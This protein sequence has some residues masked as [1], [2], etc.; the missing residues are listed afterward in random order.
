MKWWF[1]FEDLGENKLYREHNRCDDMFKTPVIITLHHLTPKA[2][3]KPSYDILK[4]DFFLLLR[5]SSIGRPG[6]PCLTLELGFSTVDYWSKHAQRCHAPCGCKREVR[7]QSQVYNIDL[8]NIINL[9]SSLC[10]PPACSQDFVFSIM[11]PLLVCHSCMC[12]VHV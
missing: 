2:N 9:K 11:Q 6:A 7:G 12:T 10:G 8:I 5:C 3:Y 1:L 4:F